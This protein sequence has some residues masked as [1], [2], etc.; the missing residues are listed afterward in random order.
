MTESIKIQQILVKYS[1]LEILGISY[2]TRDI[3]AARQESNT[4]FLLCV[5]V[6]QLHCE[7]DDSQKLEERESLEGNFT[8]FLYILAT[9]ADQILEDF[10]NLQIMK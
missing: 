7:S 8:R 5:L 9:K 4:E 3:P 10:N 6:S 2:I 1:I